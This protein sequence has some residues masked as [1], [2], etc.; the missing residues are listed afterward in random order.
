[1]GLSPSVT[2][3]PSKIRIAFQQLTERIRDIPGVEM[4]D[5]T[6][7]VP[8]GKGSNEGPFWVGSQ[9]PAS[10][11][12]IP[13][14]IYYPSG[15]NYLRT[16]KIPLLRG[17]FVT[18]ADNV[19]SELV[20]VIDSLLARAYF[21]ERD[22]VGQTITIP[23]LGAARNVAA[24]IVGVAGHVEHYGLDGSMGEKPQIY[25]SFYQLPDDVVPLFRGEVTLTAR[26]R[27]DAAAMMPA[28]RKAVYEAG[29]D[30]PVYNIHTMQELVSG[31]MGR[32]RLPMIL[33]VAFALL[34]L[35][36]AFVGTYGV[37]SYSTARRVHEIGIRM[38]L[39]AEKFD[40]LRMVVGQGSQ[41][42]F[43]GVAIG[44]AASLV[45]ART[46]SSFS[47]L[48]Y[49]VSAMDPWTLLA[50]SIVLVGAVILACYVPARRAARVDPMMA[51]RHE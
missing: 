47:H 35:L 3:T 31:S 36:L 22:P 11:A 42:A 51:L 14:A 19:N 50:V 24:H 1:V 10:M 28:I 15:P 37:I 9:Q 27:L 44:T 46:L 41:L 32:Q 33:L 12:E 16:M 25:Y 21:P 29:S 8:L 5:I 38:A 2:N 30:Q 40:V 48:L 34:A 17:R 4:A 43:I 23:H 45:L 6:A 39:G 13:R 18:R 20:V 26:T 49:G 7:L